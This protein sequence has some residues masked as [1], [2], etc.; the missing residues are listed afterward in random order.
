MV[1]LIQ[2]IALKKL[3]PHNVEAEQYVLGSCLKSKEVFSRA[4]EFIEE[5]DFY[6]T[7]HK[8]IFQVLRE[9]F[10][11]GEEI[12]LLVIIDRLRKK[13]E[14]EAV[15]G[16]EYLDFLDDQT[17][18]PSAIGHH[19]KIVREKKILRDLIDTSTEIATQS[20]EDSE[21]VEKILDRAETSIFKISEKKTKRSFYRLKEIVKSGFESI[22]RLFEKP[23]LVTGI[24]SGFT[25]LDLMTSGFQ[26]SD[27]II[28]AARPSMG[29]TSM[30]LDIARFAA[31]KRGVA[32]AVF[33]LEMSK[34][35][36]GIRLLCSEARVD[37]GKLR[38][39]YL[40]KKDW[41][42]LTAAGGRLSEAPIFVDDS[43]SL[44]TLDVR[45]RARRLYAEQNIGLIIVDYLQL[46]RSSGRSENRQLEISEISQ[47]LKALAKELSIPIIALSQLSRG[48]EGRTDKRPLLSDLRE[49][50]SI[51]QDADL[52]M[53]IYRDEVYNP[54][55]GREGL[56]EILIRKQ[57]NGPVGE[58]TLSFI[59]EFTRFE[60]H[61][62]I[63]Q[64]P[65]P[66]KNDEVP[67]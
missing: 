56:A 34:E 46:M 61:A 43:P 54:D 20:Y 58:V 17:P 28:L 1:N 13:N 31:V 55:A 36:L 3:R 51:E 12:D 15:G 62:G 48:V 44:T 47:G 33:S 24:E 14:L 16:M 52:V 59:K 45:A 8:K 19:A 6:K 21:D 25:D 29:K 50:G 11:T 18:T 30:A 53:F 37:S 5:N 32:T 9:I 49:S 63:E 66:N 41:P 57:R 26:P 42:Q 23:G 2:D 27:L 38:T 39:G 22:E 64:D 7:A 40:S 60:N 65:P 10:E 4:L 67:F 35:Q